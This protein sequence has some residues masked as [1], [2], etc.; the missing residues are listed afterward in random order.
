MGRWILD[1]TKTDF[2]DSNSEGNRKKH[3]KEKHKHKHGKEKVLFTI[4]PNEFFK[5]KYPQSSARITA[6]KLFFPMF[7]FDPPDSIRKI[8]FSDGFWGI[9][10]EHW[11]EKG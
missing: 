10:V 2:L 9:K 1:A 11:E 6:L 3:G 8:W 4:F 7:S 5:L